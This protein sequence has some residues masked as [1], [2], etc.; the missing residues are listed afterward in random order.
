M[1][2]NKVMRCH[3]DSGQ[4]GEC[5]VCRQDVDTN[6]GTNSI[7]CTGC[8]KWKHR[9][10]CSVT[11]RLQDVDAGIFRCPQSDGVEDVRA[12]RVVGAKFV[13]GNV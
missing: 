5:V 13:D 10:C 12:N 1:G 3:V 6:S 11:G 9:R 4:I 8:V 7:K 2:K